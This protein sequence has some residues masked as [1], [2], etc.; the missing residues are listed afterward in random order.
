MRTRFCASRLFAMDIYAESEALL[1][2]ALVILVFLFLSISERR[3]FSERQQT[4]LWITLAIVFFSVCSL[5][6]SGN[7]RIASAP[8][9][10]SDPSALVDRRQ[11]DLSK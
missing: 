7:S 2:L 3:S 6:F 10:Q 11:A 8:S 1:V 4:G 5:L 9:D